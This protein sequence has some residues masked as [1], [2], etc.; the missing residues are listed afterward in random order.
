MFSDNERE[1]TR[2]A[3]AQFAKEAGGYLPPPIPKA[4]AVAREVLREMFE[5]EVSRYYVAGGHLV[6]PLAESM[7]E[8]VTLDENSVPPLIPPIVAAHFQNGGDYEGYLAMNV[9]RGTKITPVRIDEIKPGADLER[10]RAEMCR[11]QVFWLRRNG[12]AA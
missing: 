5:E 4:Q 11:M 1:E 10:M 8:V 9:Q 7:A 12:I 2:S 6:R 3:I